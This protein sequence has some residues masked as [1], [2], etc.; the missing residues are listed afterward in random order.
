MNETKLNNLELYSLY[1][2]FYNELYGNLKSIFL[3]INEN[4]I[5]TDID[6]FD[7]FQKIN[8]IYYKLNDKY[9]INDN[10]NKFLKSMIYNTI[11]YLNNIYDYKKENY[12]FKLNIDNHKKIFNNIWVYYKNY[13]NQI[14]LLND[15]NNL[16]DFPFKN[17]INDG[18]KLYEKLK[19]YIDTVDDKKYSNIEVKFTQ[20]F[21][22][23]IQELAENLQ[24]YRDDLSKQNEQ[25]ELE[26]N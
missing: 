22:L 16:K 8:N 15:L 3:D 14:Y 10:E 26:L 6:K 23:S 19:N 18:S 12:N 24:K 21:I 5:Y 4:P 25:I 11:N 7:S 13:M 1:K 9:K 17:C 2:D 20:N